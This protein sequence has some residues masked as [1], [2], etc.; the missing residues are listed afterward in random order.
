MV[1]MIMR[2]HHVINALGQVLECIS[3]GLAFICVTDDR[4]EK[5]RQT[6]CFDQN[7]SMSE[8]PQS[9]SGIGVRFGAPRRPRGKERF[10]QT[11]LVPSNLEPLLD[12]RKRFGSGFHARKF[13]DGIA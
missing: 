1:L 10:E 3:Q 8:V 9:G 4:I 12:L 2:E 6:L 5:Q 11:F 7:T 13:I